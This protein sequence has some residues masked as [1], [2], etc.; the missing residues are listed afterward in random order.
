L[1][2]RER[3]PEFYCPPSEQ[4]GRGQP[5]PPP[6]TEQVLTPGANVRLNQLQKEQY[7]RFLETGDVP[8][9]PQPR[10]AEVPLDEPSPPPIRR[11]RTSEGGDSAAGAPGV[12]SQESTPRRKGQPKGSDAPASRASQ[13]SPAWVPSLNLQGRIGGASQEEPTCWRSFP[14]GRDPDQRCQG[15]FPGA[16]TAVSVL[17]PIIPVPARF[18]IAAWVFF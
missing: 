2:A 17:T 12:P 1:G 5:L 4:R 18:S 15:S 13:P 3:G 8:L 10:S 6:W 11:R 7:E 14:P 9:V 16:W